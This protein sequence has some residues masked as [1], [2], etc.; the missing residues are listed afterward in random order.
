MV[1][2][3]KWA[4]NKLPVFDCLQWRL[5]IKNYAGVLEN[6]TKL[7]VLNWEIQFEIQTLNL[8]PLTGIQFATD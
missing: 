4:T 8:E 3:V 2:N 5:S 1:L 7:G 6:K